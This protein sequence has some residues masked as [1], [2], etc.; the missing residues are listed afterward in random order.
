MD[1]E[2]V[3][4]GAVSCC[5]CW[6]VTGSYGSERLL[7]WS[8]L[9]L[10]FHTVPKGRFGSSPFPTQAWGSGLSLRWLSFLH[11]LEQAAH[12]GVCLRAGRCFL[13]PDKAGPALSWFLAFCR[14]SSSSSISLLCVGAVDPL[15]FPSPS[16]RCVTNSSLL[17]GSCGFNSYPQ[18][19]PHIRTFPFHFWPF[20]IS[21]SPFALDLRHLFKNICYPMFLC[22]G[23]VCMCVC[24]SVC[25]VVSHASSVHYYDRL[26]VKIQKPHKIKTKFLFLFFISFL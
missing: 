10:G 12:F 22:R 20:E 5:P 24:V 4:T 25:G 9:F 14:E 2:E 16:L 17:L 8:L 19:N 3:Y 23:F 1:Y 26:S 6:G 18:V 15:V 11:S 7:L 13:S 21:L